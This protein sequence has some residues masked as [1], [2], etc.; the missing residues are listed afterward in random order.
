MGTTPLARH[1]ALWRR[2]PDASQC[3]PCE[4]IVEAWSRWLT[5][6][7]AP[8]AAG[9]WVKSPGPACRLVVGARVPPTYVDDGSHLQHELTAAA[10]DLT[11]VEARLRDIALAGTRSHHI[12]RLL[13]AAT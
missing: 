13:T 5:P 10:I 4:A 7:R 6:A 12:T 1:V 3:M 2:S 8:A 9:R 11:R